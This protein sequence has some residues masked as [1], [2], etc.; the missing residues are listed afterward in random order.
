MRRRIALLTLA[1][2]APGAAACGRTAPSGVTVT[3]SAGVRVTVSAAPPRTFATVDTIP[4]LTLG[5]ADVTGPTQFGNIRGVHV[6]RRG[7]LWVADGQSGEV[8][9]FRPDGSF[10]KS[11]GRRG[12]GPGE[13]MG[14][15]LLGSF[16]GDSVAVWDDAQGR[17]TVLDP[18]GDVARVVT[19]HGDDGYP[20]NAF[21]VFRDGTALAR[22]R[23]VLQAG[24]L[25]P[26][27]I[28]PDTAVFA[29]VDY[30]SARS[31]PEGGAPGP[32]WLWTGRSSIPIPFTANPGFDVWGDEVHVTSG[33]AF[34][35]RVFL[36]GRLVESYGLD[37]GPEAVTEADRQEYV[38]M[39][40]RTTSEGP[41]RDD[42]LSVLDDPNVPEVLPAYRTIVADDQGYV[43]AERYAYGTF[44]VYGPDRA[45]L[46]R[47][48]VPLML[49]QVTGSE[50]VGVWR[51]QL[52]VEYVRIHRYHR[53]P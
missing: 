8:R 28:I 36:N 53:V 41:R 45:L 1:C 21:H 6:D 48:D 27:A 2:I 14:L 31:Q 34:R 3:D 29:R 13:F 12:E 32:T 4:A 24:A 51:D 46:G 47:I 11:V 17:L 42:Y 19:Y 50:L 49:T 20:P 10:W 26:G 39:V 38:D 22:V 52:D 40:T 16:R 30:V 18:E 7:N 44:D 23:T 43:W 33:P 15:R 9:L 5:G 35:I 25:E 37:R